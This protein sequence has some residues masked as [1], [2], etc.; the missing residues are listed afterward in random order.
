MCQS[1]AKLY[2]PAWIRMKSGEI[3]IA[4]RDRY[5]NR[6]VVVYRPPQF[7]STGTIFLQV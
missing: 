6:F 5:A 1:Q 2:S 4:L 7:N 3:R